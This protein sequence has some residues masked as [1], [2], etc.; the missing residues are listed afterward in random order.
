MLGSNANLSVLII[1]VLKEGRV[2]HWIRPVILKFLIVSES[3]KS[4]LIL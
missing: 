4:P 3:N 2:V 1:P